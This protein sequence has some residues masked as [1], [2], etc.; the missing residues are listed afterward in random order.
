MNDLYKNL[1]TQLLPITYICNFLLH[2]G[3]M[4]NNIFTKIIVF[5]IFLKIIFCFE[6]NFYFTS[7]TR[8]TTPSF[9]RSRKKNYATWKIIV[10]TAQQRALAQWKE[11][12]NGV[13]AC[14][15]SEK[16][17]GIEWMPK[18]EYV[19]LSDRVLAFL[20]AR[21]PVNPSQQRGS[22][23]LSRSSCGGWGVSDH[24]TWAHLVRPGSQIPASNSS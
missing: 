15:H 22:R 21:C 9:A 24:V 1:S 3:K 6:S 10:L 2:L 16:G 14:G 11:K 20:L 18:I 13:A 7:P 17:K 4:E 8:N 23:V 12:K 19:R 5:L